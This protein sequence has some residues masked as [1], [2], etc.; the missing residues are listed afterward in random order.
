MT[1]AHDRTS[2]LR[3]SVTAVATTA[4]VASATATTLGRMAGAYQRLS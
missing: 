2:S 3:P 4:K 1:Y